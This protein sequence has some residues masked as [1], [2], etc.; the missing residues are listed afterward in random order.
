MAFSAVF[1]EVDPLVGYSG[2]RNLKL[3]IDDLEHYRGERA[4][5]GLKLPRGFQKVDRVELVKGD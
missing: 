1:S 3:N 5:R 2:K 4:R